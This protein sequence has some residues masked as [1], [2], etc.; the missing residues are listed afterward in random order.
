[1][2]GIS[3]PLITDYKRK[4]IGRP[5]LHFVFVTLSNHENQ[6]LLNLEVSLDFYSDS[7]ERLGSLSVVQRRD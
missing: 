7:W 1:M 3:A 2:Y 5:R 6:V 4:H